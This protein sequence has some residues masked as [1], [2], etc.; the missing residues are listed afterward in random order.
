[1]FKKFS[2]VDAL[3]DANNAIAQDPLPN[4]KAMYRK[5]KALI[6]LGKPHKAAIELQKCAK[7]EPENGAIKALLIQTQVECSFIHQRLA[8]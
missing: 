8:T 6:E 2:P 3:I 5:A 1:M 4:V 7:I